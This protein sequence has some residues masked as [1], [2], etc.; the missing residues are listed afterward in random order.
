MEMEVSFFAIKGMIIPS[1]I[2]QRNKN[3]ETELLPLNNAAA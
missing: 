3:E 1:T 2:N